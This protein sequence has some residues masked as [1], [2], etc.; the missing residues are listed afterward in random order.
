MAIRILLASDDRPVRE[1]LRYLLAQAAGFTVVAEA[2]D[3]PTALELARAVTCDVVV[4]NLGET[5]TP[6]GIAVCGRLLAEH[7]ALR[8]I[9]LSLQADRRYLQQAF[10]SGAAGYL[11]EECAWEELEEAVRTVAAG[12][13]CVSPAIE[14]GIP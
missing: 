10:R 5:R 1:S 3:G 11:L 13:R 8:V 9:V 7:P 12:S 2:G 4:L 14:V 6:G